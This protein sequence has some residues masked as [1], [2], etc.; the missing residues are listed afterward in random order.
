MNNHDSQVNYQRKKTKNRFT[1]RVDVR[2]DT[3]ILQRVPSAGFWCHVLQYP[4][5]KTAKIFLLRLL[6]KD[7]MKAM[8]HVKRITAAIPT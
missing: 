3:S 1:V 5:A 4:I 8:K 7:R 2:D 6:G